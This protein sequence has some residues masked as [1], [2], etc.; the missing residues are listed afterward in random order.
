[1]SSGTMWRVGQ[2]HSREL[3]DVVHKGNDGGPLRRRV[4]VNKPAGAVFGHDELEK[5]TGPISPRSL[6][7]HSA[8]WVPWEGPH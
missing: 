2:A 6:E 4:L 5:G 1:M 3:N 8:G 7:P